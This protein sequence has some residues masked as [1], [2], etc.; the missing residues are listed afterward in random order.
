MVCQ[1]AEAD[2]GVLVMAVSRKAVTCYL[3]ST[4]ARMGTYRDSFARGQARTDWE[5]RADPAEL[6]KCRLAR[7]QELLAGSEAKALLVW[8]DENVRYLTGLRAQI[9]SGKSSVLNGCLLLPDRKPILLCSG[10]DIAR[11][12]EGMPWIDEFYSIPIQEAAG[13]IEGT[14]ETVLAS[15]L[16]GAGVEDGALAVDQVP[17]A[18]V[19]SLRHTLPRIEIGDGDALMLVAR[20][21]KF[22]QEIAFMQEAAAI[23]DAVTQTA[24]NTAAVGVRECEVVAEAMRTLYR[25]GGEMPHVATPFVASGE[26]MAPPTRLATDKIIR[27]GDIVFIDI[28]AMW[29]GY[30]CDIARA[31]VCGTPNRRQREIYTAVHAALMAG[32][33]ALKVGNTNDDVAQAVRDAAADHGF[34]DD[35]L[36]LFIGH[37]VGIG[38]NEPPYIGETLPGAETVI[39]ESAMTFALEPLI[40]QRGVRGGGGVRLEETIAVGEHG[41]RPLGRLGFDERL[42]R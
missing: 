4:L 24:L 17:A 20:Q 16:R 27:E 12:R 7:V 10:G 31:T 26:H 36:T 23:A 14:V 9:I 41:G 33:A 13:L 35:L 22:P 15:L 1:T 39:L 6:R 2:S 8:K 29:N 21:V 18:F 34:A 42:L 11:A 3:T 5:L 40:W 19:R 25:L 30:F 37:G 38:T 28:G 32:V